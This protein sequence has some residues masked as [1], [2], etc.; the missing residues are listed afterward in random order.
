MWSL[1]TDLPPFVIPHLHLVVPGLF[2]PMPGLKELG[3]KPAA[4]ALETLL[5]RAEGA[6]TGKRSFESTLFHLFGVPNGAGSDLPSAAVSRL[7]EGGE[8]D[9]AFWLHADPVFLK[10]TADRLLLFDAQMLDIRPEDAD[11]LV[12][13]FNQHFAQDGWHME[14]PHPNR[15]YLRLPITPALITIPL[16]DVVGRNVDQYLPQ[17]EDASSWRSILNEV[18]MLFHSAAANVQREV[19][20]LLPI[21]GIWLSGGGCLPE[22]QT[23]GFSV[24][25]ADDVL[26]QGFSK[27]SGIDCQPLSLEAIMQNNEEGSRLV[28]YP[29]LMRS[30]LAADPQDWVDK[31]GEFELWAEALQRMLQKK[32]IDRLSIYP[33]DGREFQIDRRGL[34]RF[35]KSRSPISNYLL[36]R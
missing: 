29:L 28:V 20:H 36:S 8:R 17:G 19:D 14:V 16:A 1:L 27:L 4:P 15:W 7:A 25:I 26:S 18:Q 13:L 3:L 32:Q 35:W 6:E 34:R 9:D 31:L 10:P 12:A 30:V 24:V 11:Q 22:V 5:A 2:G 21:N 23:A 33:C